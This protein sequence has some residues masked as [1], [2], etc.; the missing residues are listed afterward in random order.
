[1]FRRPF[2][3]RERARIGGYKPLDGKRFGAEQFN[4]VA[5]RQQQSACDMGG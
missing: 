4:V 3:Q 5:E 1:M 2:H